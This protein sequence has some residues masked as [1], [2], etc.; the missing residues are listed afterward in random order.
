MKLVNFTCFSGAEHKFQQAV[1]GSG[2]PEKAETPLERPLE[3]LRASV[4]PRGPRLSRLSERG[5]AGGS[6]RRTGVSW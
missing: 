3:A 2:D 6:E 4:D 1:Q 5:S